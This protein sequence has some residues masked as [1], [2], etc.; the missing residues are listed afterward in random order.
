MSINLFFNVQKL[1]FKLL[2][3]LKQIKVKENEKTK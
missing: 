3:N 2:N 1:H